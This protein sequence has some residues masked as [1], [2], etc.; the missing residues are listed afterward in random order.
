MK[1]IKGLLF[2]LLVVFLFVSPISASDSVFVDV[3]IGG[4]YE[5]SVDWAVGHGITKGTSATTFS[6]SEMCTRGQI[7]TFLWRAAG[8]PSI[9]NIENPFHDVKKS[10]YY[11]EAVLWAAENGITY[12][13]GD[14][15]FSP[16]DIVTRA[17]VV[18]LLWRVDG[19]RMVNAQN[20][21]IDLDAGEYYEKAVLW[22]V[23]NNI[24][25]GMTPELF[26]PLSECIRSQSVT[27]LY[28]YYGHSESN[29]VRE[30]V[31]EATCTKEGSYE[32][33][34]YC[35]VCHDEMSRKQVV[36]PPK[37][38]T[39]VVDKAVSA[40]CTKAGLTEGKHC[41]VC[42]EILVKQEVVAAKGHTEVVDKAVSATC[43]KDGLTEGKHCS[44]CN[45]VLVK[46]EA[47]SALGHDYADGKCTRCGEDDPNGDS[48]QFSIIAEKVTVSPGDKGVE[49]A[50]AVHNNPGI[51]GANLSVIYD[52]EV[53]T[54]VGAT[55]GDALDVLTFT[56]PKNFGS[57][58]G[59]VWDDVEIAPEN[60]KDG[61]MLILIFDVKSD[62]PDG[63]YEIVISDSLEIVDN[64]LDTL[65]ALVKNGSLTVKK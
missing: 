1:K 15:I 5:E 32:K 63:E 57:G 58:C 21:F 45:E 3:E 14:A 36:I 41:S 13:T 29:A 38:H 25:V 34:V 37:G 23:K 9:G 18:T 56:K 31:K 55:N 6:P 64:N 11:Y 7:M 60:V 35:S 42:D 52:A 54:L 19:S 16:D 40:T 2:L 59:F 39:E 33:V 65:N 49:V 27:F 50:I 28:R 12:G 46:Q 47:I 48:E 10:D 22:A 53:M 8:S 44:V 4:W 20:P 43:T 61:T 26:C 24:V 62:A 30:N 17:Q 51:L